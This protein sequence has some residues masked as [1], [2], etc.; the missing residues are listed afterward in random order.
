MLK[1]HFIRQ[2]SY[3]DWAWQRVFGSVRQLSAESYHRERGFFWGSVHGM[4]VH[5]LSAESIWLERS[6]GYSP[7]SLLDPAD[8]AD[9]HAVLAHWS[10]VTIAW[11]D[12]LESLS[13]DNLF[14]AVSYQSTGGKARQNSQQEILQHVLFHAMEHRSQL[15]PI[16]HLLRVPTP[17]LDYIR[18]ALEES[19][20]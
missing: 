11:H 9:F 10:T 14:R 17:P 12:F 13:D 16:L 4:L 8:Y 7:K 15:T 6:K 18:F 3:N 19:G 20:Q 2:F 5:S 1:S